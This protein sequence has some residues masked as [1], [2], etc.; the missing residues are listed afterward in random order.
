M[1]M[2]FSLKQTGSRKSVIKA[3]E[4]ASDRRCGNISGCIY[5]YQRS[6]IFLKL[7]IL[8]LKSGSD[9]TC[10]LVVALCQFC[11]RYGAIIRNHRDSD[12]PTKAR[13]LQYY[14]VCIAMLCCGGEEYW[15]RQRC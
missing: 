7:K 5:F 2:W 1:W 13:K 10:E 6:R 3:N 15:W 9:A 11:T 12:A 8:L 4:G 14:T